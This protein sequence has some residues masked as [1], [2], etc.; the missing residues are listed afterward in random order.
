VFYTVCTERSAK[1]KAQAVEYDDVHEFP[2]P[3]PKSRKT[4]EKV[5]RMC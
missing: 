2:G 5:I 4:K 3:T 1:Y